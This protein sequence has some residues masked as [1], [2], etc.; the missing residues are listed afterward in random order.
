MNGGDLAGYISAAFLIGGAL[1]NWVERSW[2]KREKTR[3]ILQGLVWV[4]G[5]KPA[6]EL[7]PA[8]AGLVQQV[9]DLAKDVGKLSGK[10]DGVAT[11]IDRHEQW[12]DKSMPSPT[13]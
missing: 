6:D 12:H 11:R 5:G 8:I 10:I 1:G 4:V 2:R 9:V 7:T 13:R 3:D